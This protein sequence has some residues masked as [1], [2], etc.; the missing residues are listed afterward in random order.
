MR[1]LDIALSQST[2][3]PPISLVPLMITKSM[4]QNIIIVW[5]TSVQTT[6][7][8]PPCDVR[9]ELSGCGTG[10]IASTYHTSIEDADNAHNWRNQVD[11]NSSNC[12]RVEHKIR[13]N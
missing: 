1:P 2:S 13:T 11:I 6:A 9:K 4:A 7:L 3:T 12:V 8:R 10:R 5:M